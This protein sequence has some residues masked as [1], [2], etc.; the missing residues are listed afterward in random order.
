VASSLKKRRGDGAFGCEVS[1]FCLI[2]NTDKDIRNLPIGGVVLVLLFL[3]L[4]VP[5][6]Q[7]ASRTLPFSAKLRHFD[8]LGCLLFLGAVTCLLLA[9][10]W[11]G[12]NLPWNS[13]TVIGLLVGF[14]LCV[15]AFGFVQWK[16][17]DKATIPLRIL[18]QRNIWTSAIV[19]FLTQA[20]LYLVSTPQMCCISQVI[21]R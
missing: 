3:F 4:K 9:L 19:L 18:R 10:Q 14:V 7:N 2:I 12:Q 11:G 5:G 20:T 21:D 15:C 17:Q 8:P 6:T 16:A 1:I 13:P